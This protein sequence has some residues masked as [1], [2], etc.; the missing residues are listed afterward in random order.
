MTKT[1]RIIGHLQTP[2]TTGLKNG[3]VFI[4]KNSGAWRAYRWIGFADMLCDWKGFDTLEDAER[5][6]KIWMRGDA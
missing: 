1:Y 2:S 3:E 5:W 4:E 6:A